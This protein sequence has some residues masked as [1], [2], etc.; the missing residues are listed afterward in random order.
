MTARGILNAAYRANMVPSHLYGKT[1]HKTLQARISEDI[2]YHRSTSVFFR[3]QP[4]F[5]FLTELI[6]DPEIPSRFKEPFS[7]R[8]RT[9]D[10]FREPLLTI[11]RDFLHQCDETLKSNWKNL[12]RAAESA[13][14]IKYAIEDEVTDETITAWTFSIVRKGTSI[15][16]YRMGRYRDD[17]DAFA[18]KRSIGFKA[19]LDS[20][21]LTLFCKGDYGAQ[22]KSFSIILN[23]LDISYRS[24]DVDEHN[25]PTPMTNLVLDDNSGQ[26]ALLVI[27]EWRCPEWFEPTTRR[28]SLNN[29]AWLDLSAFNRDLEDFEPWSKAAFEALQYEDIQRH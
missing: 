19:T 17:R 15:L 2:L 9:R 16:S 25:L 11:N 14:A 26:Q 22:E 27:M 24:I 28:L 13:G 21:D 7:A 8:R 18:D 12:T 29:L 4:G 1:Q 5:F 23:D 3:T 20:N 10:L 6:S